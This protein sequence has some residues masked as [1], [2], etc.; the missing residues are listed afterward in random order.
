VAGDFASSWANEG[1]ELEDNNNI[2]AT[3]KTRMADSAV[4]DRP[5][6][7]ASVIVKFIGFLS[8]LSCGRARA[9]F[10]WGGTGGS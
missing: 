2:V 5:F 3:A 8:V 6:S 4:K 7:N 10:Q 9:Y 1:T